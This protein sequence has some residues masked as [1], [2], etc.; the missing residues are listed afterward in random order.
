MVLHH[1]RHNNHKKYIVINMFN[2]SFTL[3]WNLPY[4]CHNNIHR[5]RR[6]LYSNVKFTIKRWKIMCN[7]KWG[8]R[9]KSATT[10]IISRITFYML[11]A[12]C[13]TEYWSSEEDNSDIDRRWE[14]SDQQ[15]QQCSLPSCFTGYTAPKS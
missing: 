2:C 6:L 15:R 8:T 10:I 3:I 5:S 11:L 14:G 1:K 13:C 12:L 9:L 4:F 7:G